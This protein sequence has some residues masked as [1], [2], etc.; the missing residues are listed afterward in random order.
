MLAI[1]VCARVVGVRWHGTVIYLSISD[2]QGRKVTAG[3]PGEAGMA[4]VEPFP[5]SPEIG[6]EDT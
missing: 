2:S 3:F 6:T 1:R 5:P 4:R